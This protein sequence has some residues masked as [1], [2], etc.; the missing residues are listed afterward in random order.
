M[1]LV[2]ITSIFFS[3]ILGTGAQTATNYAH[4][5]VSKEKH[6]LIYWISSCGE[7]ISEL[8]IDGKHFDHVRGVAKYY[9]Q[10]PNTSAIVFV[11]DGTNYSVAYHVFDMDTDKDIVIPAEYSD[12]GHS[13]GSK[14]PRDSIEL[15]D[16]GEI[17]LCHYDTGAKSTLPSLSK[18]DS[19]K[20]LYYLDLDKRAVVARKTLYYDSERKLIS[21]N[22]W[23]AVSNEK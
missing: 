14:N 21:E 19:V 3:V 8:V 15:A 10:V 12:F 1:R 13:I 11:V 2:F 5:I 9:L 6:P 23:P 20:S 4:R 17:I 7:T 18:L 22:D 16:D